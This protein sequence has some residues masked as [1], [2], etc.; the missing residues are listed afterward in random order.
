MGKEWV[1]GIPGIAIAVFTRTRPL[2]QTSER[3]REKMLHVL[4]TLCVRVY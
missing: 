2:L 4:N 3:E 1:E